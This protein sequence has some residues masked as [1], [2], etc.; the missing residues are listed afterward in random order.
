MAKITKISSKGI[1]LIKK[2]EGF[3]S[4]PYICPAGVPTIGYG[5]TYYP[6]GTKVTMKDPAITEIQATNLLIDNLATYE[7]SVDSFVRDDINQNKFDALVVFCYNVGVGNLKSSSLLKKVNINPN[8]PTIKDSF[9]KW[10]FGGDGT[11]NNVDDD[12]DGQ[13]DEAGEKKKLNGLLKRRTDEANLYF[14]V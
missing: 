8:D 7:K 13:V 11:H 12:G 4:K 10:V 9:L 1:A 5:T 14:S 2:Y 6:N 3:Y